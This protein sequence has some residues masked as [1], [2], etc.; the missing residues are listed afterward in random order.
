MDDDDGDR[1]NALMMAV[2]SDISVIER[3]SADAFG[4]SARLLRF[5]TNRSLCPASLGMRVDVVVV[6]M[7]VVDVVVVIV[8]VVVVVVVVLGSLIS[9]DEHLII[10]AEDERGSDRE[11]IINKQLNTA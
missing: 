5:L 9:F 1:S 7:V 10:H 8:A 2:R 11:K 6:V 4:H 3:W